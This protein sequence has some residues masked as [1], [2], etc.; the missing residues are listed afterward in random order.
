MEK[1]RALAELLEVY[2]LPATCVEYKLERLTTRSIS[3]WSLSC[4]AQVVTSETAIKFALLRP[5]GA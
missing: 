4:S 2:M 3:S 1:E 5:D